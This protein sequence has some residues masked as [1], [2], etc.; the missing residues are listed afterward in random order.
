MKLGSWGLHP[1]ASLLPPSLSLPC[2]PHGT[3]KMGPRRL[4]P[5]ATFLAFFLAYYVPGTV[6]GTDYDSEAS[7]SLP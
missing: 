5:F 3:R 6:Q 4:W 1:Q 2:I 7:M